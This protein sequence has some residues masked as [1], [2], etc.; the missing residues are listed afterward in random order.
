MT[1]TGEVFQTRFR[2]GRAVIYRVMDDDCSN[3]LHVFF[4]DRAA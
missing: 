2:A 4:G 1:L 3:K